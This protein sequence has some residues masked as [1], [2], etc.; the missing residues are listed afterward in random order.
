MCQKDTKARA[1]YALKTDY[2]A[3]VRVS[4]IMTVQYVVHF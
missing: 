3:F 2:Y 1:N 4:V